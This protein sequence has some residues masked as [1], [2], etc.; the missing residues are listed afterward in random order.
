MRPGAAFASGSR[1]PS[2]ILSFHDSDM[3]HR[4][5]FSSRLVFPSGNA[6]KYEI[7]RIDGS[8]GPAAVDTSPFSLAHDARTNP[9]VATA[10]ILDAVV[11]KLMPHRFRNLL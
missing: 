1:G 11:L 7:L 5:K 3:T 6:R 8:S 10:R 4:K 2:P 9:I